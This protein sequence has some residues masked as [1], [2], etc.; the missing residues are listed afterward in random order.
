MLVYQDW[1]STKCT[2]RKLIFQNPRTKLVQCNPICQQHQ[3]VA[4][5]LHHYY[6]SPR[7]TCIQILGA[8]LALATWVLLSRMSHILARPSSLKDPTVVRTTQIDHEVSMN[9]FP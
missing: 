9:S 1:S 2:V 7:S 6:F 8:Q 3:T 5:G 4:R